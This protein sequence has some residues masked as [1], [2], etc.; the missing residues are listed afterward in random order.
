MI[1][2]Y[3]PER[4]GVAAYAAQSVAALQAEGHT[5]RI[6]TWGEGEGDVRLAAPPRG[7]RLA[8]LLPHCRDAERVIFQYMP[9]FYADDSSRVAQVRSR[10]ALRRL[11]RT[12]PN[13]E[14]VVHELPW[15]PPVEQLGL[16]GRLLW[17]L[18]RLQWSAAPALHFHNPASLETFRSRFR[19]SG[20]NARV[21]DHGRHF[22]PNYA[23]SRAEA[24]RELGLRPDRI[25]LASVGFIT[26]YKGYELAIEA[27]ALVPDLPC[28]Y[29][30]V[31]SVH[32]EK[33]GEAAYL[34]ALQRQAAGDPRV[35]FHLE[36]VDDI[37]FD[38]WVRAADAILL[39][40]RSSTSSSV[41]A[42]CHLLGT[43]AVVTAA[44]GLRA[45]MSAAD[46]SVDDAGELA[47]V[48]RGFGRVERR[49]ETGAGA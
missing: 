37:A 29:H 39:P 17:Q 25:Q 43:P 18:E 15:F 20:G 12:V 7:G 30:I 40:Y 44:A 26:P 36:Y 27:L 48:L 35:R 4:C 5:V 23:G 6:V 31:G 3:P 38:R 24:R 9:S 16:P 49:V 10:L 22:R 13:L 28:E 34:E 2:T 19:L 32:P 21:I 11:F 46:A 42:R 8:E 45:E 14:V 33:P 1:S 41:L 47:A